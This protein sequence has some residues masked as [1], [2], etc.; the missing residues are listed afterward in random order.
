MGK[1]IKPATRW[2]CSL[3]AGLYSCLV[4]LLFLRALAERFPA[5]AFVKFVVD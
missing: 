4:C 3:S 5:P 2:G 1:E